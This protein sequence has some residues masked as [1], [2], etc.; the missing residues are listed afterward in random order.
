MWLQQFKCDSRD[1]R[2]PVQLQVEFPFNDVG[3]STDNDSI[4]NCDSKLSY[5]ILYATFD[6][7]FLVLNTGKRCFESIPTLQS[8]HF[9]LIFS[10]SQMHLRQ[11]AC[12]FEL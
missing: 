10:H 5:L 3:H 8:G 7:N 9:E 11:K 12:P 2:V 1:A 4:Y 6:T